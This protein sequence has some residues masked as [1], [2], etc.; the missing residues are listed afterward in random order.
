M[1]IHPQF[2]EI[3][4]IKDF[5]IRFALIVLGVVVAVSVTQWREHSSRQK[6]ATDMRLRLMDE[7]ANN[8][9][10][11]SRVAANYDQTTKALEGVVVLCEKATKAGKLDDET[12]AAIQRIELNLRT[13]SLVDTQW[14]LANANL[15]L[16]EFDKD[17]AGRFASAYAFQHFLESVLMQ[18]KPGTLSAIVEANMLQGTTS[19]EQT[20]TTCRAYLYLH[21]YGMSMRSNMELLSKAYGNVITPT[22]V[23][24]VAA[25]A[26][27]GVK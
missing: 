2:G 18:H 9:A 13:P 27:G 3:R 10:L 19:P 14:Q 16:R 24:A 25:G 26:S 17:E 15:A 5:L 11:L 21:T 8:A 4:T 20:R 12:V 1:D 7:V 23:T 22:A 6:A